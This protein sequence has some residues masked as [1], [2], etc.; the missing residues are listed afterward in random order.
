MFPTQVHIDALVMGNIDRDQSLS[1]VEGF[2]E[3]AGFTSIDHDE[4]LESL[5]MEQKQTIEAT[6]ANPIKGDTDHASL[7]QFQLGIPS[8]E[9]R[10]NL[11]VL[12]QF[13]NRRIYDSLR[14]EAQ[15][16]YI[17]GA[18][19]TQA[20]STVLLQCFVEGSKTHPDEVVK[21]IDAELARA[22]E[23]IESMP[24]ADL[25]RWKESAR[26]KLT[27]LDVNFSENFKRSAD[28]IFSHANCFT[29]RDL[30]LKYLDSDFSSKHILRTFSKLSDPS[31]RLVSTKCFFLLV[32][33]P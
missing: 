13:L 10:V 32:A 22:R 11:A 9:E 23:Q 6:L 24:N 20:A 28:E 4:A 27:K 7:V 21:L 15:L 29:R 1:L 33:L 12:A 17:V 26:A 14:T 3:Q 25:A 31:K 19:E 16:G 30:E 8:I 5:A 18:K 2:L